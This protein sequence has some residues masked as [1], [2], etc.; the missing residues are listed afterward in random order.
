M[1]RR[2]LDQGLRRRRPT[3]PHPAHHLGIAG[4]R[5][6]LDDADY[7]RHIVWT[8]VVALAAT[9]LGVFALRGLFGRG[10]ITGPGLRPLPGSW[11]D[12][13]SAA[14]AS[15]IPGGL[16][17]AAP[18]MHWSGCSGTSPSAVSWW[19]RYSSSPRCP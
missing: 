8:G 15:W 5:H 1:G 17:S 13:W 2:H 11:Q 16:G 9:T 14:W 12:L 7:G 19:S 18:V 3:A 6:G 10:E 4:T